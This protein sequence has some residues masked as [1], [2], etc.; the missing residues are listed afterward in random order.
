[1]NRTLAALVFTTL[2]AACAAASPPGQPVAVAVAAA[3]VEVDLSRLD[4]R[5][6]D[7]D[8]V[9][10]ARRQTQELRPCVYAGSLALYPDRSR[11]AL[12]TLV[13][14]V[15]KA[16]LVRFWGGEV[17]ELV[18]PAAPRDSFQVRLVWPVAVSGWLAAGHLPLEVRA[19]VELAPPHLWWS[20]GARVY[21]SSSAVGV[22]H[23]ARPRSPAIVAPAVERDLPCADLALAGSASPLP[24]GT[25]EMNTQQLFESPSP[26]RRLATIE[27][28]ASPLVELLELVE[29]PEEWARVRGF[30]SNTTFV[31]ERYAA[32]DF[33][34]WTQGKPE[35]PGE[36]AQGPRSRRPKVGP[37]T[38]QTTRELA[39][40]ID[41][42][43][44]QIGTIP[45]GVPLRAEPPQSGFVRVR[46]PG[47]ESALYVTE[48]DFHDVAAIQ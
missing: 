38:H 29:E 14:A 30:G 5:K 2:G 24:S 10:P 3:S 13:D 23:V 27:S 4:L 46:L 47:V 9:V 35:A 16:Q 8:D 41:A 36:P 48:P 22:A 20:P 17:A 42:G 32:W 31:D 7:L 12:A 45:R 44:R 18:V 21:A 40:Y 11:P 28:N 39:V 25:L 1:M 33:D 34:A 43:A 19:R 26:P 37:A 15:D 6:L